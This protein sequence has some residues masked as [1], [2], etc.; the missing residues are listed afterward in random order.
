[1]VKDFLQAQIYF[2]GWRIVRWLPEKTAYS[3]FQKIGVYLAKNNKGGSARLRS[4]LSQ[5]KP[6]YTSRELDELTEKAM[7]SYMRYWCDTFR[8]PDW[9]KEL[10]SKKVQCT[11][12]EYL[13]SPMRRGEGVIVALPHAGNWDL[14]G[15]Y[16]ASMGL[17][18]VTVAEKLKPEALFNRFLSH[19]AKLGMEVLPLDS[20]SM[21]A[22]IARTKSKKLIALVADRD[23]SESG[24][25]VSFFQG[26]ARMP[27]G[28]ALLAIRTGVPLVTAFVSYTTDGIHI[29][30]E[31]VPIPEQGTDQ[32]KLTRVVQNCADQF[33]L[34]IAKHP[35]DWH[36]LQKIWI[37]TENRMSA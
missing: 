9:S 28:P 21:A 32:E 30:F 29:D 35:E 36:M 3:L 37:D 33:A 5:V 6:G 4:N 13:T 17:P 2:T 7:A 26:V 14:A 34:G 11:N 12:E 25:P 15:A 18:L 20:R 19:R 23:L 31:K 27:A 8:S 22:L 10:I 24:V 16:F 1:M